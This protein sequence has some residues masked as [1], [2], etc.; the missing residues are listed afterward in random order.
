MADTAVPSTMAAPDVSVVVPLKNEAGT[1][2]RLFEGIEAACHEHELRFEVLFV[3]DGSDDGSPELLRR[4]AGKDPRIVDVR[5]ARN[6]G[7][8]AALA[9][10]FRM[11]RGRVVVTMDAD[12][13]DDPAEIP[14]L[15]GLVSS[16]WGVVS[17]WKQRRHDPLSRR[18]ASRLF[19]ALTRRL[20]GLTLHDFNCGLKAYSAPAAQAVTGHCYGELHRFL[21]ALAASY[22]FSV[23]EK[24]VTHHPRAE[25]RSRYG[26]ER[27]VRGACDMVTVSYVTRFSRR[28][29]HAFGGVA[30][31]ML[32]VLASVL[33]G[34]AGATAAG[35]D[36]S[37]SAVLVVTAVL[38]VGAACL[39]AIGVL[40]ELLSARSATHVPH[41]VHS[42]PTLH[43]G[44][45][46]S[47]APASATVTTAAAAPG[48]GTTTRQVDLRTAAPRPSAMPAPGER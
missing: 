9:A 22:G 1:L 47:Q 41:T 43:D 35:T 20:S 5:L 40:A 14:G 28:P 10:G 25:G 12:L 31:V 39:A 27:Y 16:G 26:L 17:G 2:E 21:P 33:L 42:V 44:S 19:N 7:K 18:L 6:F 48:T 37:W 15:V 29:M 32:V 8:A 13:Q 38:G 46:R 30:L 11:A 24:V 36:V 3:D 45:H 34:A 23:T 4:M